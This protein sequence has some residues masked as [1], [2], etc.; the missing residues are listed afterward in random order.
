MLL[1]YFLSHFVSLN[2][3][4]SHLCFIVPMSKIPVDELQLF[5]VSQA[6]SLSVL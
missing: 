6:L 4:F 1:S 3:L 2:V 5:V